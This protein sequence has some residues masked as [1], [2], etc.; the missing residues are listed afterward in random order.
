MFDS[1][2]WPNRVDNIAPTFAQQHHVIWVAPGP[3]DRDS[4]RIPA[5]VPA[6]A[7][8]RSSLVFQAQGHQRVLQGHVHD[9]DESLIVK[10]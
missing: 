2:R 4:E 5:L 7:R 6:S 9:T 3:P 8:G 1:Q 10:K